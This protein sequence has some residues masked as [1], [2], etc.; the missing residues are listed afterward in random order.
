MGSLLYFPVVPSKIFFSYPIEWRRLISCGVDLSPSIILS[1]PFSSVLP[2]APRSYRKS[3]LRSPY[4]PYQ[5][6]VIALWILSLPLILPNALGMLV[7]FCAVFCKATTNLLYFASKSNSVQVSLVLQPFTKHTSL[8][9]NRSL[10]R[11]Y[12]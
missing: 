12:C 10:R 5:C 6:S 7:L 2:V 11:R 3:L 9:T 1:L 4:Q 8:W